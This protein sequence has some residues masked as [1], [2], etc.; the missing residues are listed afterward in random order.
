MSAL[1]FHTV[2]TR[3]RDISLEAQL[4]DSWTGAGGLDPPPRSPPADL[5]A[6]LY[7]RFAG[8]KTEPQGACTPGQR[9]PTPTPPCPVRQVDHPLSFSTTS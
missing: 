2:P 4:R 8:D 3:D 1:V 7:S 6:P 5:G 9:G